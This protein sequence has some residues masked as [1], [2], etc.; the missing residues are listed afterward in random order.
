LSNAVRDLVAIGKIVKPFGIRGEVILRVMTSAP[1]RFRSLRQAYLACAADAEQHANTPARS[2][3]IE[4]ASVEP[5]GVRLKFA[6][7]GDRTAAEAIVGMLL[8]GDDTQQLDL[9]HGT[10]FVHQIIGMTVEDEQWNRIGTVQDVLHMPAQDVYVV[11][12]ERGEVMIPAVKEFIL[13]V[14][15][16]A[17]RMRVKIIEGMLT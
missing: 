4:R 2:V 1:A 16:V 13:S 17:H 5:R 6:D 9:P 11:T 7:V 10:W 12:G 14:D 3:A 15:V 8:M